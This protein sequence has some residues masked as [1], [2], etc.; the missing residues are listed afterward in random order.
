MVAR[1][2]DRPLVGVVG[3]SGAGKS[4]FVRAGV[5]PALERGE[6]WEAAVTRPGRNPLEALAAAG[7]ALVSTADGRADDDG[8]GDLAERLRREPGAFGELLRRRARGRGVRVLL[9]VDQFEE[10]YTLGGDVEE[11][12]AYL[13][14]LLGAAD[15]PMTPVRVVVSMRSDFLDRLAEDTG[16][17]DALTPGLMFLAPPAADG[18]RAALVEPAAYVGYRFETESIVDDMVAE[19]AATTGALPLLQFAAGQL[20]EERDRSRRLLTEAAYRRIGGVAGA[21]ASHADAVVAGLAPAAQSLAR[22]VLERL[23]TPE[24]TR[25]VVEVADLVAMTDEADA[26]QKVIDH[27]VDA[28]LLVVHA[29]EA[30]AAA[31]ELVHESL[32][33]TWPTLRR[34]L[35]QDQADAALLARLRTAAKQWDEA[36]RPDGLLWRGEATAEARRWRDEYRGELPRRE[37]AYLEATF[38]LAD[39]AARSRRFVVAGTIGVLAALVVAAA[40]A[41][42]WIRDAER[43]AVKEA[44]R[45]LAETER[46]REAN[47]KLAEEQRRQAELLASLQREQAERQRARSE[48]DEASEQVELRGAELE[49]ANIELRAA[50]ERARLESER[51]QLA[52][53]QALK[54]AASAETAR[55]AAD[56]ARARAEELARKES[57]RADLLEKRRGKI[58]TKLQ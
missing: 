57:E 5:I 2:R 27:L 15:D 38:R 41:L 35:D 33:E 40:F 36:G 58:S 37:R 17:V 26:V 13:A 48:A 49:Q 44:E 16:F 52:S 14:C 29:G 21:L 43:A 55:R 30:G 1:L 45:A 11:R 46:A 22:R 47:E 19:L 25:D 53:Q 6:R 56:E 51:A 7:L 3:P 18:L 10:L 42:V 28:R 31:V 39:R 9:Y 54:E 8:A 32:V 23:V 12:R 24:R 50:L 4:S 34:W 20:W